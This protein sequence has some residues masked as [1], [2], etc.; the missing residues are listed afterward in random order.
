MNRLITLTLISL[1]AQSSFAQFTPSY[2]YSL[3]EEYKS[4]THEVSKILSFDNNGFI[5]E[6]I[7]G[8]LTNRNY[9]IKKYS[10]AMK[11]VYS[12]TME[13]SQKTP[14]D[15]RGYINTVT[16]KGVPYGLFYH[17]IDATST[18]NLVVRKVGDDGELSN[19]A[20][21]GSDKPEKFGKAPEYKFVVSDNGEYLSAVGVTSFE[22][23]EQEK[24][25]VITIKS[26][27]LSGKV[28]KTIN[29]TV[30]RERYEKN[31]FFLTNT[32]TLLSYKKWDVKKEGYFTAL[33]AVSSDGKVSKTDISLE[34]RAVSDHK[35]FLKKDGTIGLLGFYEPDQKYYKRIS[36]H[37]YYN[38]DQSG[39]KLS[40]TKEDLGIMVLSQI[41]VGLE[42]GK[43]DKENEPIKEYRLVDVL[44]MENG[45]LSILLEKFDENS[46]TAPGYPP[47]SFTKLYTRTHKNLLDI[48]LNKEGKKTRATVFS[49]EQTY[50]TVAPYKEWG[51]IIPFVKENDVHFIWNYIDFPTVNTAGI[52]L[53]Q[54]GWKD[55]S[56]KKYL[57]F[58]EYGDRMRLPTCISGIAADGTF[59]YND[60]PI[61]NAIPLIGMY[62][63][64]VF[65]YVFSSQLY[66][67]NGNKLLLLM[68][69]QNGFDKGETKYQFCTL[70]L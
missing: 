19:E 43:A 65:K 37:F 5:I 2:K 45:E 3:V 42:K 9:V 62:K 18:Y 63:E 32:G 49:K 24:W 25:H 21:I 15:Y 27:D 23:D 28:D 11:L 16:C 51:G 13:L 30:M 54:P 33:V 7:T 67:R 20:V 50:N 53:P 22:K 40:G 44:E 55:A 60:Q 26:S 61:P 46:V 70:T 6:E 31:D 57:A 59:L 48:R 17:W 35:L 36:G 58:K 14:R 52:A 10:S 66:A 41:Y 8:S 38:F 29:T 34:G 56:G 64:A 47:E 69:M 68:E 12:T 39:T 4:A 1:F